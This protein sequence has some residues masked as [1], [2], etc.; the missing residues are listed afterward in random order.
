MLSVCC[1]HQ[2][3]NKTNLN[4]WPVD[5]THTLLHVRLVQRQWSS[6]AL[7]LVRTCKDVMTHSYCEI[8][9]YSDV[10]KIFKIILFFLFILPEIPLLY[11]SY[12]ARKVFSCYIAWLRMQVTR[13][14]KAGECANCV[15]QDDLGGSGHGLFERLCLRL[16][17]KR[18]PPE[19][20]SNALK[21]WRMSILSLVFNPL[22][23]GGRYRYHLTFPLKF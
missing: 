22:K 4:A 1:V 12:M 17:S 16:G 2:K 3:V 9:S 11:G 5:L 18:I 21:C 20:N 23:H 7:W 6:F 13:I 14:S 19:T 15:W 8:L 10:T